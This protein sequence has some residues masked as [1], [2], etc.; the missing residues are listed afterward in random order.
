METIIRP[1]KTLL[2]V[3]KSLPEGT[4]AQLIE[5]NLVETVAK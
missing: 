3:Y 2:E 5:N 1:P 4:N